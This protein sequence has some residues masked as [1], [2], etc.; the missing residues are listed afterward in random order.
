MLRLVGSL[1][2]VTPQEEVQVNHGT[3]KPETSLAAPYIY[4]LC[5]MRYA[6]SDLICL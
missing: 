4:T 5:A 1:L 2:T 6:L 3:L